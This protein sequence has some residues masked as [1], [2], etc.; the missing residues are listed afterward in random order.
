MG[1]MTGTM[2][3][4]QVL[5]EVLTLEQDPDPAYSGRGSGKKL[6]AFSDSRSSAAQFAAQLDRAHRQHVQRAAINKA[7]KDGQGSMGLDE[8]SM[9]VAKVLQQHGFFK[10]SPNNR[11]RALSIAFA[12]FTASYASRRRL[13]SLGLAASRVVFENSPPAELW[14]AVGSPED[15]IALVQSLL[16]MIQYDSAVTKPEIMTPL[17]GFAGARPDVYYGLAAGNKRWISPGGRLYQRRRSRAFNLAMRLVGEEQADK[18]LSDV[19][20]FAVAEE[21]LVGGGDRFQVDS[22]RLEFLVPG[23]WFRCSACRRVTPWTLSGGRGCPTRDCSGKLQP[24]E[25]VV[26]LDDHYTQ[27]VTDPIE[28][29]RI[30]EHT[31]QLD[32]SEAQRIGAQFREG[33]VNILSCSTTF[34]LGVDI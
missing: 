3:P 10:A 7:L 19:W 34:E 9:R 29:L 5:A 15:G 21:A 8:L 4:T 24:D 12:E 2:A 30:E 31:A 11:P 14:E 18:L 28:Y 26:N 6:L 1:V 16:E 13:E 25:N 27:N 23:E 22:D 17:S 20:H 32:N 33:H